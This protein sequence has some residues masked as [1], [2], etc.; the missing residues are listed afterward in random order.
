MDQQIKDGSWVVLGSRPISPQIRIPQYKTL[1][2]PHGDYHIQDLQGNIG[3]RLSL[4]EAQ[5]LRPHK[6]FSPALVE[7]ALSAFHGLEPWMPIFD[8]MTAN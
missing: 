2:G 3:R 7:K 6:S 5:L 4:K 8:E 1:A